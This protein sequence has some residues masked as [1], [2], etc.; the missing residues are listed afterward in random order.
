[1]KLGL[2]LCY[3]VD[4]VARLDF[5]IGLKLTIGEWPNAI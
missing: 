4:Q 2:R 5:G 3:G 1:M